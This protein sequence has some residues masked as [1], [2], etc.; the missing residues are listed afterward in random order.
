MFSRSLTEHYS[1]CEERLWA[2][3]EERRNTPAS[4]SKKVTENPNPNQ[5]AT[6]RQETLGLLLDH[7]AAN[8]PTQLRQHN[9]A[10]EE[11]C[12]VLHALRTTPHLP[13]QRYTTH[14]RTLTTN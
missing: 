5:R 2:E 13:I 14:T 10:H 12:T 3:G 4:K 11:K 8:S 6:F 1:T 7:N 9:T